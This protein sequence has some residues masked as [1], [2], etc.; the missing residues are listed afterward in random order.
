MT[1]AFLKSHQETCMFML[2]NLLEHG[3]SKGTHINSGNFYLIEEDSQ[4]SGVFVL[5]NRMNILFQI[6]HEKYLQP[7]VDF[8]KKNES[9]KI[10]GVMGSDPFAVQIWNVLK[11]ENSQLSN[12]Y[13][14]SEI[15]Y[16]LNLKSKKFNIDSHLIL[17]SIEQFDLYYQHAL[18]YFQDVNMPQVDC[19]ATKQSM[20]KN[21]E[22]FLEQKRLWALISEGS[23]LSMVSI[24]G[25]YEDL[26]QIG[27][28]YTPKALRCQG[29]SRRCMESLLGKAKEVHQSTTAILF[30]AQTNVSAQR[31][32]ETIGFERIG[33]Y[34]IYFGNLE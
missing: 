23:L 27:G 7:M 18:K 25:L 29:F 12:N 31:V 14:S 34:G 15:L 19:E 3:F 8:L 17:F 16:S 33:N 4:V 28:V 26:I 20:R 5:V 6:K 22:K 21:F 11:S 24:N 2:N 1:L 32:Y 30:T 13:I 10:K 9:S